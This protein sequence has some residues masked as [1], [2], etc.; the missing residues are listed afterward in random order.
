MTPKL[1]K[2]VNTVFLLMICTPLVGA[3]GVQFIKGEF[4]CPLCLLQRLAMLGIA[5]GVIMNLRFGIRPMHYGMCILSAVFGACVST[6]QVLLHIVPGQ[7][8]SGYGDPVMG[9]H[10]YTWAL[11]IFMTTILLLGIMFM[12]DSQFESS[13]KT[14]SPRK[15]SPIA[16]GA[17]WI[18]FGVT[19]A[20]VI[21]TFF[22]CGLKQCPDNP[23]SY[24]LL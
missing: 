21:T 13:E 8:S 4:P 20:N 6:R 9:L 12:F 23:T 11:L 2:S 15:V 17:F 5:C 14:Q 10:L 18:A 22:E 16:S 7:G 1:A 24:L 19:V 3:Y